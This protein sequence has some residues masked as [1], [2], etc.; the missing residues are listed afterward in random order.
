MKHEVFVKKMKVLEAKRRGIS[1]KI[2][3]LVMGYAET[4]EFNE[5]DKVLLTKDGCSVAAYIKKISLPCIISNNHSFMIEFL[6]CKKNGNVSKNEISAYGWE[7]KKID[8]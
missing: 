6:A 5:G 7:I 3:A 4:F 8:Q 2:E 1:E